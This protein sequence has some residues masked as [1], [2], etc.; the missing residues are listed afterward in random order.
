MTEDYFAM[1][2]IKIL[3]N[4]LTNPVVFILSTAL[5]V[6]YTLPNNLIELS[7]SLKWFLW[8]GFPVTIVYIITTRIYLWKCEEL[9]QKKLPKDYKFQQNIFVKLTPNEIPKWLSTLNKIST[10]TGIIAIFFILIIDTL[11]IAT[12]VIN[13]LNIL[14]S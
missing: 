4:A 6:F 3:I 7:D 13:L 14:G 1:Y 10:I 11:S 12:L 8:I 5:F 9:K 2:W